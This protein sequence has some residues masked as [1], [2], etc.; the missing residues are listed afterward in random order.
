M[1]TIVQGLADDLDLKKMLKFII[2]ISF[3]LIISLVGSDLEKNNKI[4]VP[5]PVLGLTYDELKED[6][7]GRSEGE[8]LVELGKK[9]TIKAKIEVTSKGNGILKLL[10]KNKETLS[11]QIV[12]DHDHAPTLL[13]PADSDNY[14]DALLVA[15]NFD[16]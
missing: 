7:Y 11:L 5:R 6:G 14:F 2:T 12:D 8:H 16:S 9:I 3:L 4:I 15:D 10:Y 1:I 13:V